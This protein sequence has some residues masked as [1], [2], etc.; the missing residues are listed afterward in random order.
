[1]RLLVVSW[2]VILKHPL[3]TISASGDNIQVF[4]TEFLFFQMF[5]DWGKQVWLILVITERQAPALI[6]KGAIYRYFLCHVLLIF[7]NEHLIDD[8]VHRKLYQLEIM[9]TSKNTIGIN[10]NTNVKC[11]PVENQFGG[12]KSIPALGFAPLGNNIWDRKILP[13]LKSFHSAFAFL[14]LVYREKLDSN[15]CR[16]TSRDENN[17]HLLSLNSVKL[18]L[19]PVIQRCAPHPDVTPLYSSYIRDN[20]RVYMR[21]H[22]Q[23]KCPIGYRKAKSV[24]NYTVGSLFFLN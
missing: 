20:F 1:M 7:K 11:L 10:L 16:L 6:S 9:K 3:M 18:K 8:W 24:D 4:I 5:W 22:S 17:Q 14:P 2:S 12:S 19:K 21:T 15:L 13:N 23:R